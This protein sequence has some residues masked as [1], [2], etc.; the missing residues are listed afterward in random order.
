MSTQELVRRDR[1]TKTATPA[2]VATTDAK[3]DQRAEAEELLDATAALLD[4]ID[5]VLEASPEPEK[6]YTLADVMREGAKLAPQAI[7]AW[8]G[9]HGE[10]CALSAALAG[11][12]AL[13]LA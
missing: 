1:T 13:G 2:E 12:K 11:A 8:K 7:G 6:M 10:T 5:S 3:K 9:E 4:E